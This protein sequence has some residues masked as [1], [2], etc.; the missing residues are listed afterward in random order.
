MIFTACDC[1]SSAELVV[2]VGPSLLS[3]WQSGTLFPRHLFERD[4]SINT[5][6]HGSILWWELEEV[7]W[8]KKKAVNGIGFAMLFLWLDSIAEI[9]LCSMSYWVIC[10]FLLVIAVSVTFYWSF[11][12]CLQTSRSKYFSALLTSLTFHLCC[13]FL[14]PVASPMQKGGQKD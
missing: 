3:S 10:E 12:F 8:N 2:S 11:N 9:M 1:R 6:L 4:G 14:S 13:A 7:H 5:K